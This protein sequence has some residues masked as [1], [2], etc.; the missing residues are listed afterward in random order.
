MKTNVDFSKRS[1][2]GCL[3]VRRLT[4][5][6]PAA[7]VSAVALS[8]K[9]CPTHADGWAAAHMLSAKVAAGILGRIFPPPLP[10]LNAMCELLVSSARMTKTAVYLHDAESSAGRPGW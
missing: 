10:R 7:D 5:G 6:G 4:D 1:T 3:W 2:C 9:A 8:W